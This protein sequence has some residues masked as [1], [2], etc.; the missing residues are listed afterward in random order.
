M[1]RTVLSFPLSKSF[2]T[3]TDD[4]SWAVITCVFPGVNGGV[5]SEGRIQDAGPAGDRARSRAGH[6]AAM[7]CSYPAAPAA[8]GDAS[9]QGK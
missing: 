1:P 5:E 3:A 2:N 9:M 8:S 7:A 4:I 6:P